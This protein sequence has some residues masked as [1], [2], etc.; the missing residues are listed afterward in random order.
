MFAD[1]RTD[2]AVE[3]SRHDV[4]ELVEREVDAVIGHAPL[5]EIVGADAFGAVTAADQRTAR[6]GF[7]GLL[8]LALRVEQARREAPSCSEAAS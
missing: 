6:F 1:E 5:R 4:V 8:L 2:Q 7:L 3:I